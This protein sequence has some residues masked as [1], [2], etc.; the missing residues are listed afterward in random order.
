MSLTRWTPGDAA[1]VIPAAN[2]NFV[3]R[4]PLGAT[5]APSRDKDW[6]TPKRSIGSFALTYLAGWTVTP[7]SAL[8]AGDAVN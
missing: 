4:E 5:I 2:Y 7:E 8:D 6:P 1:K 3:S